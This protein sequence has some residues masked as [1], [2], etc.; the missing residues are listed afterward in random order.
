VW[1]EDDPAVAA[2]HSVVPQRWL[3]GL[4]ELLARIAPRFVRVEPR[5]RVATFLTGLMA[6]LPRTNC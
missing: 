2:C 6:G 1:K 3:T 5:R 4:D